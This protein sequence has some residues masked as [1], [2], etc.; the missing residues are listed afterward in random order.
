MHSKVPQLTCE[1]RGGGGGG[2]GERDMLMGV[3]GREDEKVCVSGW[4]RGRD[5]VWM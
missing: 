2:G 4:V 3:R 1:R 5:G